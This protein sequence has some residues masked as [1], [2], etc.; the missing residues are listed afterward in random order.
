MKH[1]P[2]ADCFVALVACDSALQTIAEQSLSLSSYMLLA[3][4]QVFSDATDQQK[5]Q[6][7]I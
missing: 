3:L 2:V 6:A 5:I 7:F 1:V 4:G